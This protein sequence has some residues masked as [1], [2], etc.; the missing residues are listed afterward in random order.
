MPVIGCVA[1]CIFVL[2]SCNEMRENVGMLIFYSAGIYALDLS[3]LSECG[4]RECQ[5]QFQDQNEVEQLT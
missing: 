3:M 5:E 1:F 2:V 4:V